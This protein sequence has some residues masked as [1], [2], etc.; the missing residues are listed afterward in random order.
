MRLHLPLALLC[1]AAAG[2]A[3]A[4]PPAI[5]GKAL[6][7]QACA[8][9]HTTG[10]NRAPDL[11]VLRAMSAD[12]VLA[13]METGPMISMATGRSVDE[14][15]AIAEAITGKK[16]RNTL[17]VSPL[18][19]AMCAASGARPAAFDPA[20]GPTWNSWSG[21]G[22]TNARFQD[23]KSAGLTPA[24][25]PKLKL[26]WAFGFPG[27]LQSNAQATITGGRVFVGSPGGGVYALSA[28]SGCI[29]WFFQASAGV[30]S[31][32][33]VQ[34]VGGREM[35][36]FGDQ[37][38]NG[39]ALDAAT[40]AV[41]WKTRLDEFPVTRI[42]GSPTFYNGRL[43]FPV[44]S[45]EEGTGSIPTYECCH[46]RGSVVALD[47]ATGK[48]I[49]KSYTIPEAPKPT[50]KN[51]VGTQ[52]WGPSGAPVWA[53]P[54]IDPRRNA[55][56]ITTGDNYSEPATDTSDAFMAFDLDTGRMLWHRQMTKNDAY[57]SAC[58]LPDK[59]NC[60]SVNGPDFD[61]G[62]SPIL[63]DLP[64]GKRALIAGQKSGIVHALDPDNDGAILWQTR[65]G[66]GGT[67]GGVQWGSATDGQNVYVANSDIGRIMLTYSQF[68]DADTKRGG[69]MY[70]LKLE[71]GEKVWFTPPFACG[72]RARCSPAQSAA[73]SAFPGIAFSGSVDG[74][75][76]AYSTVDGKVV[77]DYDTERP[78][79]TV[80]GVD[81]RGGSIDGPGPAIGGGMVFFN[82]GYHTAG[83]QPG[84]VLLAFSVDG[85]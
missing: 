54:A 71:T 62:A 43:Y 75:M 49:W 40:G 60:P 84:N 70:A 34:R 17:D 67:M 23:A 48:Q 21:A 74:H 42:S 15:R 63:V 19:K 81:A 72:T 24:D 46:F 53:S 7:D 77:W 8:Q 3:Q 73:V 39:Y 61:F 26:K 82:S 33:N 18:P 37:S 9:C 38:G 29:H 45:G 47:A 20:S 4:Q 50:T 58:R 64:N 32:V 28:A 36:F 51:K 65:V 5:D 27:D 52:L 13:A 16:L 31:A 14:R 85:K 76:R 69:G 80:N 10:A 41:I 22:V 56:Y 57:V 79:E 55:L 44:A 66:L 83:G 78:Y 12:R 1:V 25:V 2:R 35:A 59:T 11:D 30:R 6:F 68:T